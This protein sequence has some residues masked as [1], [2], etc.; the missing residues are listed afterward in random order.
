MSAQKT[1]IAVHKETVQ[2][3]GNFGR[4]KETYEDVIN[5]LLDRVRSNDSNEEYTG[6]KAPTNDSQHDVTPSAFKDGGPEE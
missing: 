5:R 3:L 1:T 6:V 4:F 2:R